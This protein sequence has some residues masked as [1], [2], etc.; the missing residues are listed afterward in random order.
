MKAQVIEYQITEFDS[1]L[2][3]G[4]RT[5]KRNLRALLV[6]CSSYYGNRRRTIVVCFDNEV[7]FHAILGEKE[8]GTLEYLNNKVPSVL[9]KNRKDYTIVRE[10]NISK[11]L[12]DTIINAPDWLFALSITRATVKEILRST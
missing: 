7:S 8:D 5:S 10:V 4:A 1:G 12:V 6:S 3:E 2:D 11:D 9:P